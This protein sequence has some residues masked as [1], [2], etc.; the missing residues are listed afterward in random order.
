MDTK[1]ASHQEPA[2]L[3]PEFR[4]ATVTTPQERAHF[5]HPLSRRPTLQIPPETS[6]AFHE[7]RNLFGV[8]YSLLK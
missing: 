8:D 2:I 5:L 6:P 1:K 3:L 4:W 7:F